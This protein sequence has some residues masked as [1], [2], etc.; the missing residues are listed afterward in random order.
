MKKGDLIPLVAQGVTVCEAL[1]EAVESDR[2]TLL[3]PG[4]R[5]VVGIRT[6]LADDAPVSAPEKETIIDGVVAPDNSSADSGG[7]T[8]APE[9]TP[10][11]AADVVEVT[12]EAPVETTEATE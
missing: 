10:E 4:V 3:V 12:P 2:V 1:V 11:P 7:S 6:T 8:A 9:A 5:V